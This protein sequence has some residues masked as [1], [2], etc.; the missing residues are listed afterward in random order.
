MEKSPVSPK[1]YYWTKKRKL[2]LRKNQVLGVAFLLAVIIIGSLGEYTKR[3]L[4]KLS[5]IPTVKAYTKEEVKIDIESEVRRIA[6]E[7]NF[8]WTDYLIKLMKCEN[9]RHSGDELD[10]KRDNTTGNY[11]A[12]SRDR[13][14]FAINSY[15]H[16]EVSDECAYDIECSTKWTMER[17]NKG[18]QSEWM[19]N[20]RIKKGDIDF[21]NW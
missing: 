17:I 9:L 14:L 4:N 3:H 5:L 6:K 8:E 2:E 19:C 20:D 21:L 15:H 13:G 12:K 18:Y 7:N 16:Y 1:K 11:P 10:P